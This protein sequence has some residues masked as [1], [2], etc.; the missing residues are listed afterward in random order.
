MTLV[1]VA[2]VFCGGYRDMAAAILAGEVD[3]LLPQPKPVLMRLIAR[4]SFAHAFGDIATGLTLLATLSGLDCAHIPLAVV[5][6]AVG[7]VVYVSAGITFASL[8][9][10]SAGARSFA[11]D[12]TDFILM[13]SSYPGSLYSG[14]TKLIAFTILPA[15][16]VVL[17]PVDLIREPTL[18]H[19][20]IAVAAAIG[21][22]AFA[23]F[24]FHLGL[25]RCQRIGAPSGN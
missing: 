20:A 9:F 23:I 22:A 15:G 4:E 7:L 17:A 6:V 1:G 10:W 5:G 18:A 21:Y 24:V 19:L 14:T 3:T 13:F 25:K 11:R 8:A 12:L 2:G 16:F